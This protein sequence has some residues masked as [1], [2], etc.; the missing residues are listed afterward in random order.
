[1]RYYEL[2]LHTW[3]VMNTRTHG[4][5]PELS[6]RSWSLRFQ[7]LKKRIRVKLGDRA[8]A[9]NIPTF[10]HRQFYWW[11]LSL[12][13][14]CDAVDFVLKAIKVSVFFGRFCPN[15]GIAGREKG[16]AEK[17]KESPQAS[18]GRREQKGGR[19]RFRIF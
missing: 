13:N 18:H 16:R 1:M 2:I 14:L 4:A 9:Q 5:R 10:Q 12:N 8:L 17:A 15:P 6:E 19:G 11:S 3:Q 7:I